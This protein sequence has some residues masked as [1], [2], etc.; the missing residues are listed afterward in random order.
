MQKNYP[1]FETNFTSFLR[2]VF[3]KDSI[4]VDSL[5]SKKVVFRCTVLIL[6]VFTSFGF[7]QTETFNSGIPSSWVVT[8]NQTVTNNWIAAPTG[9]FQATGGASVNPASNNTQGTTAEYF[10]ISPQLVTPTNGEIRFYVKQ[11][12]FTNRGTTFQL[13]VSTANQPDISSF[14]VTLQ[15]WTEAQLNVSATTYEEKIVPIPSI[16]SGIPVYLALVAITNQTGTASTSGDTIFVDN[17]RMI[18]SC[19]PVTGISTFIT[20]DS[21]QIS[22]THPTAT[23]F[24]IEVVP[25]GAGHGALGTPV[26]GTTYTAS[27]LTSLTTYDVYII[28]NC[29]A[30]TSSSWAGPFS[31]TTA[32]VGLTCPTAIQVPSDVTVTPYVYSNNL[33]Q[34]YDANTYVPYTSQGL[35]CSPAG[36]PSTWNLFLGNHAFFSFTP[37][38]S[39]LVNITQT[40]NVISGGGGNNCYN[41]SSSLFIFDSCAG[42]GTSAGC[43]GG[44]RTDTNMLTAGFY[45]FY[46]TAGQTYILLVSSPYQRSNPGA[47]ICFTLTISGSTCPAPAVITYENLQQTSISASWNNVQNL[48]S[49][50]EYIALPAGDGAPSVAQAGTP[51]NTNIENPVTGLTPGTNYNLYV[52]SVCGGIPGPWSAPMPFTTQCNPF[53]LPYYT[54]F[55]GTSATNPEPCW[56]VLNLNND[57]YK[58]TFGNNAFSEPCARLRTGDADPNDM[59]ITPQFVFDGVTQKRLRFKYNVY[60]NWGLIVDNPPGGPGSFEVLLSTT[61]VGEDDFTTVL[62]PLASYVTQYNFIEMI[63][64]IPANIVGNVNIAWKLPP[65]AVQTGIQFYI[66]DVYIEDMPACSEPLY[67]VITPGTI[68]TTSLELSWTNGYNNTQWQISVQPEGTGTPIPSLLVN[69]NP[70]TITGLTPG[71]RYEIYVRAY[72]NATEQSIWAG[73]IFF[74]TLCDPQPVPYYES[75]NDSDPNTK[76]FCWSVRNIGDDNTEWR[77]EE[78]DAQ[79]RQAPSF[80]TPFGGFDDWLL[81][82]PVNAVGLKR[83]RYN[84]RVV[85]GLFAPGPRGN[86]EVLMSTTPDFSTYTTII[87]S[88]DFSN[89]EYQERTALFTGTGVIYIAF[90]V[91]P[92]MDDPANS[93]SMFINDVTI[94]DAPACPFPTDL[95]ATNPT[96]NGITLGWIPGYLETAWEVAIQEPGNGI[97]TG[98][99]I[100]VQTTPSY[101]AGGLMPNT[102]YEYYVRAVCDANTKSDWRGPILFRTDCEVYP[103]PFIETFEPTSNTKTCWK[104]TDGNANGNSWELNSTV[105]P[106]FGTMMA[107]MFTG[108]NGNNNDWLVS[109]TITVQPNQRLRF[110]YKVYDEFFEEDLKIKISTNGSDISQ[111]NTTLYEN[112]LSADTDATG[113]VEG[114]NTITLASAADA[115][116]VRAG[117]FIYIPN[118]PFPYPTYVASVVGNVV[119]M[120]TSATITQTGV[121]NVQFEHEVI[122]NEEVKEM[123]INLSNIT[124]PTNINF[125]FYIP[126]YP[127]NP[128]NYRSQLLFIDNFIIEDIPACP[129]VTNVTTSNII[130]TSADIDWDPV[131]TETSWEISVQPYGTPVPV[132]N[133]L[134]AYLHTTSTHPYTV[135]GLTPST[136]YQYYVRAVCS[137]SSQSEWVGPFEI[138]TKCDFAN[139]CEY[140]ISLTS[141]STGQVAQQINV[142]Q[143]DDVVQILEFPGFG[144]PATLDYTVFLCSGVEFSLYWLGLGS[145]TQYSQ[146]QIVVKDQAN[147]VIWTSPLGLGDNNTTLFSGVA[148]CG[149][150]TCPQPT[151]LAVN[152]QGTLSWTP[153]GTE[154]QWEVFI[155]PYQN[156]T[157]P[158]SGITVTTP[159]YTPSASD[160]IDATAGTYEFLVRAVCGP[161]DKS[162]WSG[163]QEF[164]RNDEPINAIHLPVNSTE[165]CDAFGAMASFI[166]STASTVPTACE[167]VNGGDVWFDFVA[168]SKVHYIEIKDLAPGSY[169]TSSY[170]SEFPRIMMSL[171][172]QMADN[173][174]VEMG[175]SENNSFTTIYS[176]ELVVGNTYK[177]RLKLNSTLPNQ[178]TFSVCVTTPNDL[179]DINAFNYDL[180]KPPMQGVTGISTIMTSIVVP[181]WRTNTDWGT[182]FFQ[183][184][185]NTLGGYNPYSGGQ[186]IQ[187]TAD[188]ADNWNPNDPNI[189]G[190]YKDFDTSELTQVDYSFASATRTN[191][192]TL[193]LYAG[194]PSGPFTLVTADFANGTNWELVTGTYT[195]PAGQPMTRFIFRP[196][197]N[198][199]GHILDAANFKAPVDILTDQNITLD[200]DATTTTVEARGVGLW[201]AD[202]DNPA[203]AT[204]VTPNSTITNLTGLTSPGTYVF[205]WKTRY[206]EKMVT[207]VKQGTNET[208]QVVSPVVYCVND[209]ATPLTATV[210]SGFTLNWYTQAIGGTGSTIAPTPSTTTAG[211]TQMF[212]AAAVDTNGCEGPRAQ[213]AIQ[214]NDLP[215]ATITGGATVCE[216]STAIITFNGT[217]N[218][219]ITY[220]VNGGSNQTITLDATGAATLTTAALTVNTS[221]DLVSVTSTGAN[222]CSQ[223]ITGNALVTIEALPT[224][225]ISGTTDI[226]EGTT[227]TITFNGTANATVIYTVDGGTNQTITL[228]GAGTATVTTP[229]LTV[230]SIYALVSVTASGTLACSQVQTGTATITVNPLPTAVISGTTAIC[231]GAT[232]VITFNGTPNATVTYTVDG[233]SNQTITLDSNG[234]AT[235]TTPALTANSIYTLVSVASGTSICNQA[236]TGSA[237]V[238]VGVLPTATISGTTT[239]CQNATNPTITFTGANGTEPYTF[240]YTIN[241]GANQTLTTTTGNSVSISVPTA[242]VGV[243]TYDLVS[244][245]SAGLTSCSQ[246]QSGSAVVTVEAL[247]TATI[248]GTTTICAGLTATIAF[249]GTANATVTYTVNGGA[250]QTIV[251]D[252]SGNATITTAALTAT[253]TYTLVSVTS[254]TASACSQTQTSSVVI[255][256]NPLAVPNVTF[257]YAN[258][259]SNA[260][261]NPLPILPANFTTGGSFS[262]T[263][264][265]VNPTTG[266]VTSSTVGSHQITYTLASNTS[267]C[268][269]GGTY[270]ATLVI[271]EGITPVTGFSYDTTYCA[272]AVNALPTTVTGFTAGG[273]FSATSGLIIN[274]T[275]G[276]INIGGSAAGNYTITYTIP[277]DTATCNVGGTSTFQITIGNDL[278]FTIDASCQ[279]SMLTLGVIDANFN[280]D[281]ASYTWTQGTTTVGTNATLNVDE[282]MAQNPSLLLP[283]VFNLTVTLNGCDST[284]SFTVENNPCRVIPRGISP[285]DDQVNDTFDLTGYGVKDII[286][287]NRYGTKVFSFSGNYTNQW[288]GQS[289][290]GDEL[291]DGTY[292]YSIHTTEGSNK[293]GW[294]YINREY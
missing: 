224:V 186:N 50:W 150:I 22:W 55:T 209:I 183:E 246:L 3:Q 174:L 223:V 239:I 46:V 212:Y 197:G 64:P 184:G 205:Y 71:T 255:T 235:V 114:S 102:Q 181:G 28:T 227:A 70:Y 6:L 234:I 79:I 83:L 119:T 211:N 264:V 166:G 13:R 23:Q 215:T 8:S 256:V 161:N 57:P 247:P 2:S 76:K 187:I 85:P 250:N 160:F 125:G 147:N 288:R 87:P 155:Q 180:E 104:I 172:Q 291:P 213:I 92:T 182:I 294:V 137:S 237:V 167:G 45:N 278:T 248:S 292:F 221:F 173:S 194:P 284:M 258:A 122:N 26:T 67:P 151:N 165:M 203:V 265:T 148:T 136:L 44:V 201:I 126:Y 54:G 17:F 128:W 52:R 271:S 42:V 143:N 188:G 100:D 60:G 15:S 4:N 91:P 30:E 116:R 31:F 101:T 47:G 43:L 61:G 27:G 131:G 230:N 14:N 9:G 272:N 12:S 103:S 192:S 241:G 270:T 49:A 185:L 20:S 40:A 157:I 62:V 25:A 121:Q 38:T 163:P 198:A 279:N 86:F 51:T 146:A 82:G 220:T 253:T 154:T 16:P 127:P 109:P 39:G 225:T 170:E 162:Y 135:N 283:L 168:T 232:T 282:F 66:D 238:T 140:T 107:A 156:G 243:F 263:S 195:V 132:G 129:N 33:D 59:L 142:I 276:E 133:T 37:S 285:N 175:C 236:V 110:Y 208:T 176:T 191:G 118:F 293:T 35:A 277:V 177:I 106:I 259:C 1:F 260:T 48:V 206:C 280:A 19:V 10:L 153:G 249:N 190:L 139:V 93:G 141:G 158:Q 123:I 233:G 222:P 219:V 75:L 81:S 145:G 152:N 159:F 178:K 144:Q 207:I 274:P 202:E 56:T 252:G 74:H 34:F 228:N 281:A 262:S 117:D 169:Y 65:G 94:D 98:N 78:N 84:Y 18:E 95:T 289:D 68:T 113:V 111:F 286:I 214:V 217:P 240:T 80:F 268:T 251:L 189:K 108:T 24:G 290:G 7:A 254:S 171:Y 88:H 216:G 73:P 164:I 130:D 210:A 267:T 261:A 5:L 138:L 120:T 72:C 179:C 269:D 204:I 115:A 90:R 77:I 32:A 124:A 96:T 36:T 245:A 193:Q 99:G 266:A 257:S 58:F 89:A 41:A 53:P 149:V 105:N 242:T 11:G 97:P 287:F 218:A 199:V 229:V 134:P 200:C 21:A 275:T 69:T 231:S 196:E 29:N 273:T 226:C 244:V 112:S 63:V